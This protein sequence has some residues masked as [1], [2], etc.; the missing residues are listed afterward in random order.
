M[1]HMKTIEVA[2]ETFANQRDG[3]M[4][5]AI[6]PYPPPVAGRDAFVTHGFAVGLRMHALWRLS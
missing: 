2:H 6:T 4:K 3:V 1:A 5:M